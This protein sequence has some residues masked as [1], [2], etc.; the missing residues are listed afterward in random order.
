M[1]ILRITSIWNLVI[2]QK[3]YLSQIICFFFSRTLDYCS[4]F[5]NRKLSILIGGPFL[6]VKWFQRYGQ[7]REATKYKMKIELQWFFNLVGSKTLL[8]AEK[9]NRKSIVHCLS[10]LGEISYLLKFF[11]YRL[12][13]FDQSSVKHG[14]VTVYG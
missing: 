1:V 2:P 9:R 6:R 7:S 12:L 4:L 8:V 3:C 11:H 5:F 10:G 14:M 13:S